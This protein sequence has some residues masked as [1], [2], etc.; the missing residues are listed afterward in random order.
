MYNIQKL[1]K[2]RSIQFCHAMPISYLYKSRQLSSLEMIVL[3][4]TKKNKERRSRPSRMFLKLLSEN[5]HLNAKRLI[6]ISV[7]STTFLLLFSNRAQI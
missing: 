1:K 3:N 2:K 7:L 5:E 4:K 6:L